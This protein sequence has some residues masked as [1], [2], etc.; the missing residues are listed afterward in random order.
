MVMMTAFV[1]AVAAFCK[2]LIK[3]SQGKKNILKK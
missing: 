2:E 1:E 3:S